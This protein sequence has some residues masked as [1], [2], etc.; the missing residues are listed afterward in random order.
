[1]Q[2][3]PFAPQPLHEGNI[4]NPFGPNPSERYPSIAEQNSAPDQFQSSQPQYGYSQPQQPQ[5]AQQQ[6]Q[7]YPQQ[8]QQYMQSQQTGS[9]SGFRPSSS[10]GQ[11]LEQHMTGA[12]GPGQQNSHAIA[13]LDPYASLGNTQWA[14][15]QQPQSNQNL[16]PQAHSQSV[17]TYAGKTHPREIVKNRKQDLGS[18]VLL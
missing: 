14:N 16:A 13:D 4:L 17:N 3:N 2:N 15:T 10:F 11:Q 18:L 8:Q 9:G 1:M 7:G 12:F 6:S 5:Y